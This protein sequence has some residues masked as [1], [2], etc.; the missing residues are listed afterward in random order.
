MSLSAGPFTQLGGVTF[1]SDF[2]TAPVSSFETSG[3]EIS[4][5]HL[6]RVARRGT[7]SRL[8]LPEGA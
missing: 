7:T 4:C 2:A 6:E 1:S 5:Y 8:T 3:V